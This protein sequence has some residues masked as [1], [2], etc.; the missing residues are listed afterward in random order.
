MD[1]KIL[2]IVKKHLKIKDKEKKL[3]GEVFTPV[4]LIFEMLEHLPN[5]LWINPNLKWLEPA[6][7]IGNFSIV[8]YYKLMKGLESVIADERIRS[9]HIIE[10]MLYMVELNPVNCKVCRDIFKMID[11]ISSPNLYEDDFLKWVAPLSFDVIIGNPPFNCRSRIHNKITIKCL[12][13]LN[14]NKHLLLIVPFNQ[15]GGTHIPVYRELIKHSI[16][17]IKT[18]ITK[19]HFPTIGENIIYYHLQYNNTPIK[20]N[21]INENFSLKLIYRAFNPIKLWNKL[22]E[23]IFKK[24]IKSK[25]D[26]GFKYNRGGNWNEDYKHTR[27]SLFSYKTIMTY[28]KGVEIKYSKTQQK[29]HGELKVLLH[30]QGIHKSYLDLDNGVGPHFY[31]KIVPTMEI[32]K[33]VEFFFNSNLYKYIQKVSISSQFIKNPKYI[34][35]DFIYNKQF[36]LTVDSIYKQFNLTPVEIQEIN[37]HM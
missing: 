15:F 37:N 1:K 10:K 36:N 34:D 28:K 19:Q 16:I 21:F 30:E 7:G 26:N 18:N 29:G 4:E 11:P 17:L 3:F 8:V 25:H 9:S 14:N 13:I 5:D 23:K 33:R 6:N 32:A 27:D 12:K 35:I 2:T 22:S 20:T 24:V 31:Y